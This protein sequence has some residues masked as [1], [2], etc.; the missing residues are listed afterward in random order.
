MMSSKIIRE[1]TPAMPMETD[2]MMVN[3]REGV[4]DIFG[5]LGCE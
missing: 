4:Y 5:V 2:E 1:N 3:A